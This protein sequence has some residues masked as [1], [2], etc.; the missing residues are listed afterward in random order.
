MLPVMKT[1]KLRFTLMEIV[2]HPL[3]QLCYKPQNTPLMLFPEKNLLEYYH[4]E[5]IT[6]E[7][8]K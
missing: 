6:K 3:I 1:L 8:I 4:F 2:L 5:K 7:S